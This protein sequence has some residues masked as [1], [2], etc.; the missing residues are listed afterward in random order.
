MTDYLQ[1]ALEILGKSEDDVLDHALSADGQA[2]T[3]I[4]KPGPKHRIPLSELETAEPPAE[5][6]KHPLYGVRY[7][8]LQAM[9]K[10]LGI[11]ANQNTDDLIAAILGAADEEE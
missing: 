3:V 6:E 9:A 1:R 4:V 10:E 7:R 5:E 11:P 2:Y 8:D